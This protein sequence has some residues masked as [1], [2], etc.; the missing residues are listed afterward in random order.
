VG[1]M[2]TIDPD[3]PVRAMQGRCDNDLTPDPVK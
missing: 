1:K 2:E 3:R